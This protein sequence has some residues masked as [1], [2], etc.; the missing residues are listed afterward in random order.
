MEINKNNVFELLNINGAK[1]SKDFG[2]NFL[3]EPSICQ[4]IADV[5]IVEN[6]D[7]VL[8]IGPGLGSLTHFLI[9]KEGKLTCVDVDAKMVSILKQ[10][11]TNNEIELILNDVRKINLSKYTKIIGNLPYNITTELI[12]FLLE[13]AILCKQFVFMIQAEAL[14]R[15]IEVKGKYYGPASVLIHLL[16]D[17]K[18]NFIVKAGSFYPAPKCNSVVFEINVKDKYAREVVL[19]V[20]KLAK[21]LFLNRRKTLLNNLSNV[22]EKE[23][24]LSIFNQL[25]ILETARI[26]EISP[27]KILEIY[28]LTK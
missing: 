23:K 24:A 27:E 3:I 7:N 21:K 11:Y 15:F 5:L 13:N 14:N 16:G 26:E 25:G 19:D 17:I 22:C 8:E 20:Y 18:K 28:K 9:Q 10:I 12:V 4:K 2:Q 6:S 1:P